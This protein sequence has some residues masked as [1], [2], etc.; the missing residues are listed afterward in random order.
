MVKLENLR[1]GADILRLIVI[2]LVNCNLRVVINGH[3]SNYHE[4]RAS[5]PLG[6]G[7]GP[8]LWNAFLNNLLKHLPKAHP[9]TDHCTLYFSYEPSDRTDVKRGLNCELNIVAERSK[10][11]QVTVAPDETPAN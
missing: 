2:N 6:S 4:I 5:V 3:S 10:K 8:L 1:V 11:W 9:Y 7:L